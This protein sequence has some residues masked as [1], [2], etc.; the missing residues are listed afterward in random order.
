MLCQFEPNKFGIFFELKSSTLNSFSCSCVNL[1][2]PPALH[3][4]NAL[5]WLLCVFL[6]L[7]CRKRILDIT[8]FFLAKC[9][10]L[11]VCCKFCGFSCMLILVR[12]IKLLRIKEVWY[13]STLYRLLKCPNMRCPSYLLMV[14]QLQ[15]RNIS[16]MQF[17][18]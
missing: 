6:S 14:I 15:R 4:V 2:I 17:L 16:L 7:A 1:Q 9:N 13:E 10:F 5:H 8:I 3:V 18:F 11:I 12:A